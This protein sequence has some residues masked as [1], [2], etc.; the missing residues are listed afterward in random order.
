MGNPNGGNRQPRQAAEAK[1]ARVLELA[2]QHRYEHIKDVLE[3]VGVTVSTFEQWKHRNPDYRAAFTEAWHKNHGDPDGYDGTFLSFRQVFLG[4]R[5]TK[6]Q[7]KIV[8]AIEEARFSFLDMDTPTKPE[9]E[10]LPVAETR[11]LDIDE[12][13]T[14]ASDEDLKMVAGPADDRKLDLI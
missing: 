8:K 1:R 3:D 13:T 4:M 5:T 14:V 11:A 9:G 6:F 12:P 7:A 2:R 10:A